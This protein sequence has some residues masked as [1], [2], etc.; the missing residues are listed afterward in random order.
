MIQRMSLQRPI[1]RRGILVIGAAG[2]WSRGMGGCVVVFFFYFSYLINVKGTAGW[3]AHARLM[4]KERA[5]GD[6]RR[7]SGG[8]M[9]KGTCNS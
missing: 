2:G 4:A 8:G 6:R 5:Q 7:S 9:T 1:K 3:D